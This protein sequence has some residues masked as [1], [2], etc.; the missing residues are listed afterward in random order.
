MCALRKRILLQGR[1]YICEH[2]ICFYSHLF[3][4]MKE[5]VIPLK[6]PGPESF[7]CLF[8]CSMLE[9][10]KYT[11][12][13]GILAQTCSAKHMLVCQFWAIDYAMLPWHVLVTSLTGHPSR[14]LV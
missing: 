11:T 3:G 9:V 6:V 8:Q 5:K 12:I 13:D 7:C 2:Y 10:T 1:L 14:H 4:Y